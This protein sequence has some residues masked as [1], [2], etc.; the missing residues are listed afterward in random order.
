MRDSNPR[1]AGL[2]AAVLAAELTPCDGTRLFRPTAGMA[3]VASPEGL[4]PP[5]PRVVF[6]CAVRLRHRE[7]PA[8]VMAGAA[9]RKERLELS[10]GLRPT[11]F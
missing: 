6:A 1:H 8:P 11:G 9:V 5:T 2:E 10:R 4:E 3:V 7:R